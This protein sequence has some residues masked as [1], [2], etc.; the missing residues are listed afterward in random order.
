[1]ILFE[2]KPIKSAINGLPGIIEDM[3]TE[4]IE[5][6]REPG[7][8]IN[9][10]G[11]M[12]R[13][14]S[15]IWS[16][17]NSS[18]Y[19]ALPS[20]QRC[21]WLIPISG[22]G[23]MGSNA[24]AVYSPHS[25]TGKLFKTMMQVLASSEVLKFVPGYHRFSIDAPR[26]ESHALRHC[27]SNVF[28]RNDILLSVGIGKTKSVGVILSFDGG[29]LGFIK[30]GRTSDADAR[31]THEAEMLDKIN[32]IESMGSVEVEV[33]K[34]LY[35][36]YVDDLYV[37]V[38]SA[39]SFHGV[40]RRITFNKD[41]AEVLKCFS[42]RTAPKEFLLQS[43]F[44]KG[45]EPQVVSYPIIYRSILE[46]ALKRIERKAGSV[47]AYF[48]LSHGDFAPWNMLWNGKKVVVYDWESA[49]LDAPLGMDF[50]HFLYNTGW[51]IRKRTGRK[52]YAFITGRDKRGAEAYNIFR[53]TFGDVLL[54]PDTLVLLYLV[55]M[56]VDHDQTDLLSRDAQVRREVL[57]IALRNQ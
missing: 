19:I 56:S 33:P 11:K 14:L 30:L 55:K 24:W 9:E 49:C 23:L 2:Q 37:L 32:S 52:L 50:I 31:L 25:H 54:D 36:G 22:G 20:R 8:S 44:Y 45:L 7:P 10:E 16:I 35:S 53:N 1:M 13:E 17:N 38:E 15:Y 46:H 21:R 5:R 6:G 40:S 47:R 3:R 51:L 57:Q 42:G 34:R 12:P 27:L 39:P 41:Y 4:G 26:D 43:P 29:I 48:G 28:G 18:E